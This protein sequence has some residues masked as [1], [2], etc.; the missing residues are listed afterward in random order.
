MRD[1]AEQD[2]VGLA[3]RSAMERFAEG[4]TKKEIHRAWKEAGFDPVEVDPVRGPERVSVFTAYCRKVNWADRNEA[5]LGLVAF[6]N[7][8]HAAEWAGDKVGGYA[9][10]EVWEENL[11]RLRRVLDRENLKITDEHLIMLP[12]VV[13]L[14]NEVWNNIS[15]PSAIL[16]HLERLENSY[17]ENDASLVIGLSKELVESVAKIALSELS[18]EYSRNEKFSSL[19]GKTAVALR[20]RARDISNRCDD[21]ESIAA[22]KGIKK[23]LG[24][25]AG[26]VNGLNEFRNAVGTGHGRLRRASGLGGRHSRLALDAATLWCNLVLLTLADDRAPWR[27][28]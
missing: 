17:R 25:A 10:L 18:V 9:A 15:D 19:T 14:D 8:I 22:I 11:K 21:E 16:G 2:L 7:I 5:K 4:I 12:K 13:S 6:Q 23:C 27:R 20:L 1:M 28:S 3:V 26:V 24:G